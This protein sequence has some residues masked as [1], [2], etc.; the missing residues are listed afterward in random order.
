[1]IKLMGPLFFFKGISISRKQEFGRHNT[2]VVLHFDCWTSVNFLL[3]RSGVQPKNLH[4]EV[5]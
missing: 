2:I 1:M 3:N 4:S 5:N